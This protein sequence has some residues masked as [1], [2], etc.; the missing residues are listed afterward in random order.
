MLSPQTKTFHALPLERVP[1]TFLQRS[2]TPVQTPNDHNAE[3]TAERRTK[4]DVISK[5]VFS[6]RSVDPEV[7]GKTMG[8]VLIWSQH[9]FP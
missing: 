6:N 5:L 8:S 3:G 1:S 9:K 2:K 4:M 7:E